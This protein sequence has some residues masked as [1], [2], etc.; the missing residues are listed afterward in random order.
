MATARLIVIGDGCANALLTRRGIDYASVASEEQAMALLDEFDPDI[1]VFDLLQFDRERCR[2]LARRR[3][4]ASLSPIFNA[5]DEVALLFHRTASLDPGWDSLRQ[6]PDIR[7]GLRYSVTSPYCRPI[8]QETY[9]ANLEP[10]RLSIAISMGGTDAANKT[11][12]VLRELKTAPRQWLIWVLLGEGYNHSYQEI[13]DLMKGSPHEIIL[14]KTNDSM[15]RILRTCS[16]AVLAAGTTTYEAAHAG[17]PSINLLS[18]PANYYLIQE[19]VELGAAIGAAED[20]E[21]SLRKLNGIITNLD[22]NRDRLVGMH[23]RGR[24]LIDGRGA[25]RIAEEI[26]TFHHSR[27]KL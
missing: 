17:L 20:F 21:S 14:A 19:L 8:P 27:S 3:P 13:V 23:D 10:E 6:G 25:E 26:L 16:L 1:I 22:E 12:Q 5:L 9:Q 11:I 2:E 7:A 24:A 4:T 15:W 18:Q